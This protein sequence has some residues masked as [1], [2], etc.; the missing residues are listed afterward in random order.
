MAYRRITIQLK[1]DPSDDGHLLLSDFIMQFET[2]RYALSLMEKHIE[3]KGSA[4]TQYRVVDLRHNSPASVVIEAVPYP[5]GTDISPLV[6]DGFIDGID[7]LKE[8]IIPEGFDHD[9][10][11][12]FKKIASPMKRHVAEVI[13]FTEHKKVE[14][15][16]SLESDID[17]I[18]GPDE[19][20]KGS[21]SGM[22]E[23]LNIHS[24]ANH[25]R[26][27][28]IVGPKKVDCHF[29]NDQLGNAIEGINHYVK[30]SGTLRYKRMDKYPY[31]V[32]VDDI[33]IYPDEESLPSIFD[34]KGMSPKATGD[35]S[36]EDFIKR[37]RNVEW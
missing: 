19:G 21:V 35:M 23:L 15:P 27:Y 11:Q 3:Q 1:G 14:V 30:V 36:S 17:E 31:A 13:V 4:K 20:V 25:F 12:A 37:V 33:E 16:K 28:P 22:F 34:L 7:Q 29:K 8:G 10:I 32:N 6:V 24:G 2:I 18:V 9:M 5:K 26:I